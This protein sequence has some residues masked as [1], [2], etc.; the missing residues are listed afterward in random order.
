MYNWGGIQ[1]GPPKLLPS[2]QQS[3]SLGSVLHVAHRHVAVLTAQ[4]EEMNAPSVPI[5]GKSHGHPDAVFPVI[6][7]CAAPLLGTY[8]H[9]ATMD[10]PSA[11]GTHTWHV[12]ISPALPPSAVLSVQPTV[13]ADF[14]LVGHS[15]TLGKGAQTQGQRHNS[16]SPAQGEHALLLFK[17]LLFSSSVSL[18]ISGFIFG[19]SVTLAWAQGHLVTAN[20]HTAHQPRLLLRGLRET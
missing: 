16:R 8:T 3:T 14:L 5:V 19:I 6:T 4:N 17:G 20:L 15:H 11:L 7:T 2:T 12:E 18:P 1:K 13:G 9:G 10:T